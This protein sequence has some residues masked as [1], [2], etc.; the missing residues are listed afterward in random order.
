MP[1]VLM[2]IPS[3]G[4]MKAQS[5][6]FYQGKHPMLT[7]SPTTKNRHNPEKVAVYMLKDC[8][9]IYLVH[10]PYATDTGLGSST[11]VTNLIS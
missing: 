9:V 3:S 1:T 5:S 4:I 7:T 6:P 11:S 8:L 10:L 2:P